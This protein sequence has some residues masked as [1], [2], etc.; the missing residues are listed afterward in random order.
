MCQVC[1]KARAVA[2]RIWMGRDVRCCQSCLL[3][4]DGG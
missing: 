2:R 4:N 1:R 3:A